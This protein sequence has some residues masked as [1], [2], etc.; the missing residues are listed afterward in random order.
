M[1]VPSDLLKIK[2]F[3]DENQNAISKRITEIIYSRS[4]DLIEEL[5]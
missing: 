2:L 1:R 4:V 3:T 5:F